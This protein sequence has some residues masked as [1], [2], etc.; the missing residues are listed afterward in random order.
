MQGKKEQIDFD[1]FNNSTEGSDTII[2]E[3][4]GN[5]KRK[6]EIKASRYSKEKIKNEG[7]KKNPYAIWQVYSP[8][9]EI[10]STFNKITQ[11]LYETEQ[12]I[13]QLDFCDKK[14]SNDMYEDPT[15]FMKLNEVVND[16]VSRNMPDVFKNTTIDH[17]DNRTN[18]IIKT[19]ILSGFYKT[20]LINDINTLK[21]DWSNWSDDEIENK[22]VK[23]SDNTYNPSTDILGLPN[24]E[25]LSKLNNLERRY[26]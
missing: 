18:Q 9:P 8:Q 15:S 7:I 22:D 17:V 13:N 26:I 3:L 11:S 2:N 24:P 16:T 23:N 19:Q 5:T 21:E 1:N 20:A 14:L 25:K 6:V 4:L 10:D 12:T